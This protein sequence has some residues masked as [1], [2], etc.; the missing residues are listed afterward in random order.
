MQYMTNDFDYELPDSLI[1]Q[2]PLAERQQSRMLRVSRQASV[3]QDAY[4]SEFADVLT[5]N[6]L[7]IF[8]DTKV[9]PARLF[10]K[11]ETG[12]R[13]ECLIERLL[14]DNLVLAHV[15][16]SKSPKVGSLLYFSDQ[17]VSLVRREDD[18]FVLQFP[19]DLELMAWLER[20]GHVPLP[21]YITRTD[22]DSDADRYQ[23]V[24][25]RKVGAVAAPTASL[26]FDE[27]AMK[28]LEDKGVPCAFL[29]LHVGAGT[30]Q[31]VRHDDLSHHVMHSEYINVSSELCDAI[32]ACKKRGGRV[33]AAGTTVLRA[34]ESAASS[35]LLQPFAGETDLFIMPGYSFK[36]VDGLLTNFHLP[37]STLLMLVCAFAGYE[38]TMNAYQYAVEQ[39]YRF[40]SYGDCMLI[41]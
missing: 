1:A 27:A 28:L 24:F 32:A 25:A 35:G 29:T 36:V 41:I 7:L 12:G 30:F 39:S 18:L 23:T 9:F 4:F 5:P 8:N 10:G 13:V 20:Y 26:H 40:F 19:E 14:Q 38:L 31:P 15:N 16:A 21:P 17:Q 37:K 33:I 11:K 22:D 2:R 6:D 34:L 3:Y